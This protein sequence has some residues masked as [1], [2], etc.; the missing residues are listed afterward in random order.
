MEVFLFII[1]FKFSKHT[2]IISLNFCAIYT[3][4]LLLAEAVAIDLC[5]KVANNKQR[6]I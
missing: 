5:F 3:K 2:R 4:F 1:Q 6:L